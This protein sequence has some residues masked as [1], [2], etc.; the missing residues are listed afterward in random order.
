[1]NLR[2]SLGMVGVS[3][4]IAAT[5]AFAPAPA[6]ARI[7][8]SDSPTCGVLRM[9]DTRP[10]VSRAIMGAVC[11]RDASSLLRASEAQ[12]RGVKRITNFGSYADAQ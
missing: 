4:A 9:N 12:G 5:L 10:N 8:A 1:M 3:A 6:G 7:S 11:T 2:R